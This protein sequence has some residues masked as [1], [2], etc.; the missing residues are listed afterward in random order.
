MALL[1]AIEKENC[2]VCK[3]QVNHGVECE[4]CERWFHA[5]CVSMAKATIKALE[6]D[7]SLH[8]FFEGCKSGVVT[9]W[10]KVKE[11]QDELEEKMRSIVKE[12]EG[13]RK[14]TNTKQ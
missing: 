8:W 9:M 7:K 10:K 11:R 4:I 12:M 3:K 5:P 14:D 13:L 2:T 1:S 6:E